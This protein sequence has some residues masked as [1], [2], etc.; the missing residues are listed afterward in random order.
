VAATHLL[1]A[2]F[3]A[4]EASKKM[5]AR[6]DFEKYPQMCE[7]MENILPLTEGGWERRPGSKHVSSVKDSDNV[8][9]VADFEFGV[10]QAYIIEVGAGYFRFFKD[11]GAITAVDTTVHITNGTFDSS[12]ASWT[13][14]SGAGGSISHDGTNARLTLTSDGVDDA[15]AEQEVSHAGTDDLILQFSVYGAP[16]DKIK[17]RI[18]TA[19]TGTEIVNDVE[20]AV[21]YHCYTFTPTGANFF[22]QFLHTKAKALGID[23]VAILDNQTVEINTPYAQADLYELRG[24]QSKDTKRIAHE[25]YP[26]YELAR[27]GHTNWS[28]NEVRLEDGPWMDD[29]TSAT[30]L[31]PSANTG[32]GIN[33]TLSAVTGVN[34]DA[35]WKSTDI[36][37]SVRYKKSS[38]WGWAIITSITSTTVAVADVIADFEATPS[39]VTT[40]ALGLF[41]GTSG[42]AAAVGEHDQ[43]LVLGGPTNAPQT[44]GLSQTG[45]FFNFRPD[46]AAGTVEDDDGMVYVL[47]APGVN[48]IRWISAGDDLILGTFKGEWVVKSN[49]RDDVLTPTNTQ[50][51][52]PT[53]KGS[54]EVDPVRVGPVVLFLQR[55]K[56]KLYELVFDV[57]EGRQKAANLTRLASH[58]MKS[59]IIQMAFA[60]EP[61]PILHCV[62]TDGQVATM[63]Y[64]RD[65]GVIAW[66][67]QILGGSFG[68]GAAVVESVATIPGV[69]GDEVWMVVKRTINGS[70]ARHLEY[71]MPAYLDG[72]D[73]E[74]AFY[75]DAGLT[76]DSTAVS[77][78]T[79]LTHLVGETVSIWA[80]GKIH[81]QKTVDAN[82]EI[83][84]DYS[85]SVVQA[86]LPYTHTWKSLKL[87]RRVSKGDP[88]G[89]MS[90]V[91]KITFVLMNSL[92]LNMGPSASDTVIVPF[93]KVADAMGEGV[94]LFTGEKSQEF[95]GD[96]ET[97]PRIVIT[98]SAPCPFTCLAIV[99]EMVA[100]E[101]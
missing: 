57:A 95:E 86:G 54:A 66:A 55:Y 78:I 68:S 52:R 43:R 60:T 1:Q 26:L 24:S 25:T 18:G 96:W 72:D 70:T 11:R 81:P 3:N 16:G 100:N 80:D 4:G 35:G 2:V 71:F 82:G 61:E 27:S 44:F 99:P 48:A 89:Q 31:L 62:R 69:V 84:L 30:T 28:L 14:Q 13:D 88:V 83:A 33:L 37:R 74:D 36:G 53:T 5:A 65:E 19:T 10:T 50:A 85:A 49:T 63:T 42:Y 77:T 101:N 40:W 22:V 29:N 41:S 79:G 20:F 98:E 17:L 64:N 59:K 93:R 94:P 47:S 45:D 7:T 6:L 21:G 12:T 91:W 76:Y 23:N 56:R 15:H 38:T 92:N 9:L 75:V 87:P 39:A 97:D 58:I 73:A 34:D 90:R 46:D 51:R 32:L 8:T 67:R